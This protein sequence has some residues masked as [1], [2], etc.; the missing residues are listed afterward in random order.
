M[1][2][3]RIAEAS[4]NKVLKSLM[5]IVTPDIITHFTAHNVCG[6]GR[7][8]GALEEHLE[9]LEHIRNQDAEKAEAAMSAHLKDIVNFKGA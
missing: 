8:Y 4:K 2:H 6:G 9:I 5:L 3:M 1:F 7:P